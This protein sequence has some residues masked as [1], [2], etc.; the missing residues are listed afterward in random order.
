[1]AN[2]AE[3]ERLLGRYEEAERLFRKTLDLGDRVLGPD[4][5]ETAETRH[6]LAGLLAQR[7]QTEVALPLLGQ[8]VDHGLPPRVELGIETEPHVQFA[9][10]RS[11]LRRFSCPRQEAR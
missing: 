10:Q 1:M 9:S 4:Q 11:A 3:D 6:N 8:A 7:G 5:P 2:L